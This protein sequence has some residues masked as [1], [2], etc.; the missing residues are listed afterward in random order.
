VPWQTES[1]PT[2]S[3]TVKTY[4]MSVP[5]VAPLNNV[6]QDIFSVAYPSQTAESAVCLEP[7]RFAGRT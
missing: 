4:F 5:L 3:K 7:A 1:P 2:I 6:F